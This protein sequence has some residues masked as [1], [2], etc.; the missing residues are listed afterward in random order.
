MKIDQSKL[1]KQKHFIKIWKENG[2]YGTLEAATG[3]GKTY[4]GILIIKAML[5]KYPNATTA[6][7]VPSNYLR[8]KWND[9]IK[10]HNL[11]NIK[12]NT[13]HQWVDDPGRYDLR[14]YEEIHGYTGG[15]IF[16]TVFDRVIGRWTLGL[17]AK[18]RNKDD[19]KKVI[20][21]HC[22][23]IYRIPLQ[24]C[25]DNDWVA[26]F[27]V[28]NLGLDI[29]GEERKKYDKMHSSFIKYFSTFDFNLG[30]MY[31]ALKNDR[32]CQHLADQLQWEPKMIKIHAAQ[33][34]RIMQK[35]KKYL[36]TADILFDT[37]VNIINN[38][39]D[40]RI[41]TFS[42]V[43]SFADK[44]AE[45]IP[46]SVA[47]HSSLKTIMVNGKKKGQIVRAREA[48][49]AF[50]SKKVDVI[51]TARALNEGVDIHDID[52]SVKTSFNSTIIDSI[53]RTGRTIRKDENNENKHAI[54]VNLFIRKTQSERWLS[55]SQ[56]ETPNVKYKESIDEIV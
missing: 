52:M 5:K 45:A 25:L 38:F 50:E 22:P 40:K 36:Y 13:V 39:S 31:K 35:R 14:I 18:E 9:E 8:N 24:E 37:T 10:Y 20:E 56:R 47:Y 34:N 41:I 3:F 11:K 29:I 43:T 44:L 46:N 6:I 15:E 49:E 42:E 26:P 33:A 7:I 51:H 4:V 23:I 55:K 21:E 54:E 48:L 19:D 17:T 32:F 1:E 27:T 28:Y 53:Q 12:V 30:Q 16:S 2:R